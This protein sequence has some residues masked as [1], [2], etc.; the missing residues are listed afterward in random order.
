M[1][2]DYHDERRVFATIDGRAPYRSNLYERF[3]ELTKDASLPRLR[4]HDL[5][6]THDTHLK[7]AG[8]HPRDQQDRLAMRRWR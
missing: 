1:G 7:Q 3:I 5:R 4:L 8:V 6:H 2:D